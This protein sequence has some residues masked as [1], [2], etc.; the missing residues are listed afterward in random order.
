VIQE[1]KSTIEKNE[2]TVGDV[3]VF[4]ENFGATIEI[5]VGYFIPIPSTKTMEEIKQELNLEM[6]KIM[7]QYAQGFG[8]PAQVSIN[9][10]AKNEMD[11]SE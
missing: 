11:I 5:S 8:F 4:L 3:V 6:Y 9:T 2:N 7:Y 10:E 1:L